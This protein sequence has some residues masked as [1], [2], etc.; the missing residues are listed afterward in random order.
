MSGEGVRATTLGERPLT[1]E[2]LYEGEPI[3]AVAAVDEV[4]A[5]DAIEKIE[6]EFEPL[7]STVDPLVSLRPGGPNARTKGNYWFIPP[8]APPAPAG[9]GQ[10]QSPPRP[11]IRER[12]WTPAELAEADAG[13]LPMMEDAPEQWSYGDLDAGFRDAALVLDET[14]VTPDTSNVGAAANTR[15]RGRPT[16]WARSHAAPAAPARI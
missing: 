7:P 13:R 10:P 9:Q 3:L 5:A 15:A 11:E 12:K 8:P 4:T 2:P 14:F 16:S 6:I 1:N